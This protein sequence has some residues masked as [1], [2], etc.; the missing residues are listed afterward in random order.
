MLKVAKGIGKLALIGFFLILIFFPYLWAVSTSLKPDGETQVYPPAWIPKQI[1]W[2]NYVYI[3]KVVPLARYFE[4]TLIVSVIS[5]L[6]AVVLA[7]LGAYAF[8]RFRFRGKGALA[9][10]L[11][12]TEMIPGTLFLIPYYMLFIAFSNFTGI[13]MVATYHGL[14]LT[15]IAF[16][17]PFA[18]WMLRGFF[19]AIPQDLE[20]AAEIDGCTKTQAFWRIAVPLILPGVVAVGVISFIHTWNE[21]LF[22]SALTNDATRTVVLGLTDYRNKFHV[23]WNYVTAA[24]IVVSLP[25]LVIFT[26]LQKYI[27]SGLTA[28]AVKQ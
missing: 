21:M 5:T 17:L 25:V 1:E 22:A 10:M 20:A 9:V 24:G 3:W 27:V 13:P 28:G 4:N 2:S 12:A 19:D 14:I 8:S 26:V 16:S 6:I 11:L 23:N 15:Y 18:V 7:L